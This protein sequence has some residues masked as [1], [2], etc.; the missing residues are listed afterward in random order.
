MATSSE[1]NTLE[2]LDNLTVVKKLS[3]SKFFVFL[4]ESKSNPTV[5]YALKIYPIRQQTT[6]PSYFKEALITHLSHPNIINV[7][8]A[9]ES[10]PFTHNGLKK[11]VSYILMEYAPFGDFCDLI[12]SSKIRFEEKLVRTFF[13][14]L[15]EG[16][17]FL[18]TKGVAH[19]DLKPENLLLGQDFLLKITDFDQSYY[20]NDD[21]VTSAG[22]AY[23]RAP[24]IIAQKCEDPKAADIFSAGILLFIFK[25][26]GRLPQMEDQMYEGKHLLALM[27]A[28]SEEFWD[29]H[30][31]AIQRENDFFDSDFRE[32]FLGMTR[33]NPKERF[34]IQDIKSCKWYNGPVYNTQELKELISR[35]FL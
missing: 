13:H 11:D 31:K 7:R 4:V 24:E 20:H 10:Q 16:L 15:I 32:L 34:T 33:V 30:S 17:E 2:C 3:K 28:R 23:H 6:S 18:H 5:Q 26:Q 8:Q 22:T 27:E 9:E 35:S 21:K 25:T 1:L 14:Q 29:V 19:L 12:N